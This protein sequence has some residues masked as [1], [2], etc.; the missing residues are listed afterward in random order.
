MLFSYYSGSAASSE[1][2]TEPGNVQIDLLTL[3]CKTNGIKIN[4]YSV[5]MKNMSIKHDLHETVNLAFHRF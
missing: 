3:T 2:A 5:Y 4:R 1:T